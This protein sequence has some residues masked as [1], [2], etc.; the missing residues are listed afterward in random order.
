MPKNIP[1]TG[2]SP[3]NR[4]L[5]GNRYLQ[6]DM[7][8]NVIGHFAN[9]QPYAQEEVPFDHP[10]ILAWKANIQKQAEAAS[11]AALAARIAALESKLGK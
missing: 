1:E 5:M 7:D 10:D 3:R 9:P 6:R 2:I 4:S 8:G 11:F